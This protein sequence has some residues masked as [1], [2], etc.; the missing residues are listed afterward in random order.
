[1]LL[2]TFSQ[3][4]AEHGRFKSGPWQFSNYSALILDYWVVRNDELLEIWETLRS[5][6]S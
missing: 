5:D 4:N 6:D 3:V 1:M 2:M